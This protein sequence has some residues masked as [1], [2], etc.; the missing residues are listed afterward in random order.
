[1]KRWD[2][3][4]PNITSSA[5]VTTTKEVKI[6]YAATL[7]CTIDSLNVVN[8]EIKWTEGSNVYTKTNR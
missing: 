4:P 6:G 1:M 8:T 3:L 2:R 7:T 5:V